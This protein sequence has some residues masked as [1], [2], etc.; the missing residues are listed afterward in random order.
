MREGFWTLLSLQQWWFNSQEGE[1]LRSLAANILTHPAKLVIQPATSSNNKRIT[2]QTSNNGE[3]QTKKQ[4][5]C[6]G[7]NGFG[8]MGMSVL[9]ASFRVQRERGREREGTKNPMI[10]VMFVRILMNVVLF[11][12]RNFVTML[13]TNEQAAAPGCTQMFNSSLPSWDHPVN[14]SAQIWWTSQ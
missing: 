7:L 8:I 14:L 11:L 5:R 9:R 12:D 3:V 10:R 1:Y 4:R 13:F 6:N 2:C